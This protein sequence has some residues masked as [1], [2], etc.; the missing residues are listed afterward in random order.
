MADR[1]QDEFGRKT[2]REEVSRAARRRQTRAA[3]QPGRGSYPP[4]RGGPARHSQQASLDGG[5]AEA[6]AIQGALPLRQQ[7]PEQTQDWTWDYVIAISI[8]FA[9]SGLLT[10]QLWK[11]WRLG[12]R[13][14]SRQPQTPPSP[15]TPLS[16]RVRLAEDTLEMLKHMEREEV[17]KQRERLV[18][19]LQTSNDALRD[20]TKSWRTSSRFSPCG[21]GQWRPRRRS[22]GRRPTLPRNT[23]SRAIPTRKPRRGHRESQVPPRPP[24]TQHRR[25]N[26]RPL[27]HRW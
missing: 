15:P 1:H 25:R 24:A 20:Q 10:L 21:T 18:Q 14:G 9:L 13:R 26:G 8:F 5:D 12:H 6:C 11:T 7:Q 22:A 4:D 3:D 16:K 19:D 2:P 27:T 23:P 17:T